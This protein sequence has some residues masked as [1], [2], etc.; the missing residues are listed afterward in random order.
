MWDALQ[1]QSFVLG[2]ALVLIYQAARFGDIYAEDPVTSRYVSLLPGT[3]VRDFAGPRA[4]TGRSSRSLSRA[5]SS[6]RCYVCCPRT[7]SSVRSSS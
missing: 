4:T 2:A 3:G 7:L 5:S 6:I 1:T